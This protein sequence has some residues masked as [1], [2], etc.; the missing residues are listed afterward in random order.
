MD[1]RQ[2]RMDCE[3]DPTLHLYKGLSDMIENALRS[4]QTERHTDKNLTSL[5]EHLSELYAIKIPNSE[6]SRSGFRQF[7]SILGSV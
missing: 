6:F 3:D 1:I 2:I 7:F 5:V 4:L